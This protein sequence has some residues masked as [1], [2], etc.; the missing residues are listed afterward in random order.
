MSGLLNTGLPL[1]LQTLSGF[2]QYQQGMEDRKEWQRRTEDALTRIGSS[3]EESKTLLTQLQDSMLPKYQGL[4]DMMSGR[5]E[6]IV[7]NLQHG[8]DQLGRDYA[9]MGGDVM[10]R[11]DATSDRALSEFSALENAQNRAYADRTRTAMGMLEGAGEQAKADIRQDYRNLGSAQQQQLVN[12]GM[13][14]SIL[15]ASM[16]AGT[17]KQAQGALG[18]LAESLRKE[19]LSTYG[20]FSGDELANRGA[21]GTQRVGLIS[22]FGKGG[23]AL[24]YDI[25]KGG[26]D[27]AQGAIRDVTDARQ[28][29]LDA[30]YS[31]SA[32]MLANQERMGLMSLQEIKD[33]NDRY[34]GAQLE[35]G[36]PP[37]VQNPLS[38]PAQTATTLS[39]A[40]MS[41]PKPKR[42]GFGMQLGSV[43]FNMG[44]CIAADSEVL[45]PFGPKTIEAIEPGDCV[46]ADD[47]QFRR[48][49]GKDCGQAEDRSD[50]L[51]IQTADGGIVATADHVIDGKPAGEWVAGELIRV[52]GTPT[53]ILDVSFVPYVD[54]SDLILEGNAHYVANG[55][56]VHSVLGQAGPEAWRA[57]VATCGDLKDGF[58][59]CRRNPEGVWAQVA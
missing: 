28:W 55:F 47:G 23:A 33:W 9:A 6:G 39:A 52:G 50:L 54:T 24:K 37:E 3:S 25:G 19:Q 11:W 22:D 35:F 30:D 48:V 2:W 10:S 14:N 41:R 16:A 53:V 57:H 27:L 17:E 29:A 26:V 40:R 45:T 32:D 43:G 15:G 20:A 8:Y 56:V 21:M 7:G 51:A 36:L 46:L 44:G 1:L 34:V 4:A 13:G 42:G 18:R 59:R 12:R 5:S 58:W 31:A 38:Y 49:V